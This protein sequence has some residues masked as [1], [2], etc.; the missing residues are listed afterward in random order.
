MQAM[1]VDQALLFRERQSFQLGYAKIALAIPPLA[2]LIV[3]CRQMIWHLP[4]GNPATTSANLVFLTILLLAVYLRLLTVRLVT[5]LR[6]NQLSVAMKGLWRRIDIPTTEIRGAK[7]VEYQAIRDYGGYGIRSGRDG[8]AYIASGK[9]GVELEFR[10]GRK[11]LVGTQ[12]PA[13]LAR[14]ISALVSH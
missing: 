13:E 8:K 14:K 4:W 6:Q 10:T 9:E 7:P 3:T 12:R 11:L 2:L 5:E 1:S